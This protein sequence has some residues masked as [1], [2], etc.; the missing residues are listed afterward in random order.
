MAA[1]VNTR[2]PAGAIGPPRF[3]LPA[4]SSA[5]RKSRISSVFQKPEATEP[6]GT[7]QTVAGK[8]VDGDQ[9]A[10]RRRVAGRAT[11]REQ[12]R[13]P[14]RVGRAGLQGQLRAD[15]LVERGLL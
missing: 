8:E 2:P 11:R 1:A 4:V 7:F 10:P 5:G 6:S 14:H 12:R 13:A 9:R 3:G 15:A